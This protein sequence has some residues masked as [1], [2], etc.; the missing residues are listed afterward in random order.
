M[1]CKLAE[2]SRQTHSMN[3]LVRLL[4]G[5]WVSSNELS[6]GFQCE[7]PVSNLWAQI[8][9]WVPLKHWVLNQRLVAPKRSLITQDFVLCK[10]FRMDG[11]IKLNVTL[12]WDTVVFKIIQP[13]LSFPYDFYSKWVVQHWVL[14]Q[15]NVSGLSKYVVSRLRVWA[16]LEG[17]LYQASNFYFR[18]GSKT[19]ISTQPHVQ[20][21]FNESRGLDT[22]SILG[23]IS[24]RRHA[25][26]I[27]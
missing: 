27:W 12:A 17:L 3:H 2:S 26:L 11:L 20:L 6:G 4:W 13:P 25:D 10:K 23:H 5:N 7:L 16:C 8:L 14:W 21:Y 24:E 18:D 22:Y 15:Q 1:S 19:W 9:H